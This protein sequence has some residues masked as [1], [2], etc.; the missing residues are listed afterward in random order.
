MIKIGTRNEK[1]KGLLYGVPG[2][3]KT[4]FASKWEKPLFLDLEHG[5]PPNLEVAYEDPAPSTFEEFR[6]VL[7]NFTAG[8]QVRTLVI[9][10]A[11]WLENMMIRQI[12]HNENIDS[13]EKFG[14]GYGK[15]WTKL[16]EVWS[17]LLDQLDRIRI[18]QDVNILFI[19]HSKIKRYEPADMMPYDRYTLVQN[20]KTADIL[21]KWSDLILFVKYDVQLVDSRDAKTKA[22]TNGKKYMYTDFHPCWDAKNRFGLAPKLEFKFE[23]LAPV[24]A[25]KAA[26]ASPPAPASPA[27]SEPAKP[28]EKAPA[29]NPPTTPT[30]EQSAYMEITPEKKEL[31]D[32]IDRL[33]QTSGVGYAA[34]SAQI[35]KKGICPAGTPII[36]YNLQTLQRIIKGW[37]AIE[38]NI[39]NVR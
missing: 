22:I 36:Q 30:A 19:A 25:K 9:D 4:T 5:L 14:G 27:S 23:N 28:A 16:C 3:G 37:A 20:E 15:G 33:V 18:Q 26:P 2:I 17:A 7:R 24:F 8:D 38:H 21:K 11:D 6:T 1:I 29:A 31:L 35:E 12:C 13:L 32:Q 34:L 39:K 10:S